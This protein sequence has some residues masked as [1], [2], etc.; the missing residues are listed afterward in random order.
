VDSKEALEIAYRSLSFEILRLTDSMEKYEIG[1]EG[2]NE[3]LGQVH[4]VAET[5]NLMRK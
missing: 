1:A 2:Y 4:R 5:M 3:C